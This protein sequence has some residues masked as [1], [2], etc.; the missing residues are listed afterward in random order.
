MLQTHVPGGGADVRLQGDEADAG[1]DT[2]HRGG[3]IGRRVVH[4]N[5]REAKSDQP[6]QHRRQPVRAVVRQQH[7][8]QLVRQRVFHSRPVGRL[9]I[10][11]PRLIMPHASDLPP[12]VHQ[13]ACV[14]RDAASAPATPPSPVNN[15]ARVWR[16]V[17]RS[18]G[19]R[20]HQP[21]DQFLDGAGLRQ[22]TLGQLVR[23]LGLGQ[24]LI[25]LAGLLPDPA[26][27]L[28]F[29]PGL[30]CR[31]S[32]PQQ[33]LPERDVRRRSAARHSGIPGRTGRPPVRARLAMPL[34]V[35]HR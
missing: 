34:A 25:P 29:G 19:V 18:I 30:V 31:A 23:Q 32:G 8:R 24:A 21:F 16:A 1:V 4:R 28:P 33:P 35:K 14:H 15:Q 3:V 27:P 17:E 7:H 12:C 6:I 26:G 11:Q 22:V 5:D 10:G 13:D 2:D 20:G 9:T